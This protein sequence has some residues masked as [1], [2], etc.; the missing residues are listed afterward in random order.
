MKKKKV[1]IISHSHWDR[2]WYMAYE[3]HHMRLINLIDDLLDLFK[4]DPD[5]HSFHLDGQTIILEDYLQVR[6]EKK[7][8]LQD[9]ITKGKLRIGPFYILQDGFLTSSESNVRNMLIGKQDCD[10]W[11]ASVPL[12]YFPDTFGNMGQTPQLMKQA[13]LAAAA[14]GRGIRPTGFNNQVNTDDLYSSPFSEMTWKGPDGSDITGLL[15]AN[16]YSN[17]NEIPTDEEEAKVYW[18][19]K[20]ADVEKFASTNQLLMMNGVDH[21]PVQVDVTKAIKVANKL[22]PDYQFVHSCFEDYLSDLEAELPDNLTTIEGEITSQETD[23]WYTLANTASSRIYLKQKNTQ[24]SRQ[25]E[26][27]TEPLAS[28]AYDISGDYP[29][30]QLTYAWKTLM[31]NHPHDSI[32]GC[33]IDAVHRE[34]MPRFDKALEVGKYLA[35]E[36]TE[37]IACAIDTSSFPEDSQAFILFNTLGHPKEAIIKKTLI[38]KKAPLGCQ[39]PSELFE[40]VEKERLALAKDFQIIDSQHNPVEGV[41]IL[42]T[43]TAFDYDLPKR[44]FREPYFAIKVTLEMPVTLAGMSYASYALRHRKAIAKKEIGK[45]LY[46]EDKGLL[47]NEFMAVKITENGLLTITDK[48]TGHTYPD[49]LVFEDC[50][51][52]GNEYIFK[53]SADKKAILGQ[54][55]PFTVDV[56]TNTENLALI[57]LT[58]FMAIPRSADATL[59]K[60][61]TAIVDVTER[62]AGR[63]QDLA[64]LRIETDIRLEKRSPQLQFTTRFDNHMTNHR[65]RVLFSS[66][67]ET[68]H[69]YADSIFE[70]VKRPNRVNPQFWKNP[71]NPQHQEC[72]VSLR[73]HEKGIT[74]GNFGLNEYEVL[75]DTNTIALTLLRSVGE[76]GDWG[77][78]PTP[79][80]QCL[81]QQTLTY[82]FEAFSEVNQHH[83]YIRCQAMQVPFTLVQTSRHDGQLP[84][85]KSYLSELPSQVALTAYKRR[86]GDN[87][88]I[89]RLYNL[90]NDSSQEFNL[91]VPDK[92]GQV[93]NLLEEDSQQALP[94]QLGKG[95]I[96]TCSWH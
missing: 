1:H 17:G 82:T 46:H 52:I 37:A 23:G 73:D 92:K 42:A 91:L 44:T 87:A 81:G 77:Y 86:Q 9:A 29:H 27:I 38:W 13:N 90:S 65:L 88:L 10:R 70:T 33:S 69:H 11:G 31:Q 2:E 61:M 39:K 5:F 76:L 80:A 16:W 24:V 60:E 96:L 57:K 62:T 75:P 7:E 74:I 36:A 4:T 56:L 64:Q 25:L 78:F 58:R 12:G 15:F 71:S 94:R 72:F 84:P 45:L 51:D 93:C 59:A 49:Q 67:L 41:R 32:C 63:S 55:F 83:S 19:Q 20:L 22:F 48:T 26:N 95:Q 66:Q 30:D 6:P 53:Q 34:M 3:Q 18:T 14:F 79:E 54:N 68:D 43:E 21:Q 35:T 47:E 50:G 85:Q 40:K 89:T 8:Q 28:M